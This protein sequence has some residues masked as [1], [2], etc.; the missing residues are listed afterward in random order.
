MDVED[1]L[2]LSSDAMKYVVIEECCID[3]LRKNPKCWVPY[4][5]RRPIDHIQPYLITSMSI[6][7]L[8]P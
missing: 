6:N 3:P 8:E 7:S 5:A 1:L 2:E 4:K